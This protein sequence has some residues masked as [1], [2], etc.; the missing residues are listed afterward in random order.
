MS[1]SKPCV[2]FKLWGYL[3]HTFIAK[4]WATRNLVVTFCV[5]WT[6]DFSSLLSELDNTPDM[7]AVDAPCR[8]DTLWHPSCVPL[9][10]VH[11]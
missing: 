4:V 1:E 2:H 8:Y 7:T 5:N 9:C 11:P 3:W 10:S 6:T